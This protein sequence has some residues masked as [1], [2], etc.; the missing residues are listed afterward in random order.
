[1]REPRSLDEL[2]TPCAVVDL[3]R[4]SANLDKMASYT[5]Q[6]RLSL[7]PHTKTHKTPEL[8]HEQ[9]R[10]GASGVTVA[11][12]HEAEVMSSVSEN[13][14]L[15]Y[16]PVSYPKLQRLIPIAEKVN[17]TIA[18]DS[19]EALEGV[20]RTLERTNARVSV[21]VEIDAGMHR[22]G[23][24]TPAD[25]IAVA[26]KLGDSTNTRFA[27]VLFYPGHIRQH[28]EEQKHD[29]ASTRALINEFLSEFVA[30]GLAPARVSGGSTPTAYASHNFDGVTEIRPGTYIFN[31]RTTAAMGACDWSE[32]AYSILAT[33]VSTS[34]A[35]QAVVDAGSKAVFK[36]ELRGVPN[37]EGFGALLDRPDVVVKSMSE[38]HGILDL[39]RSTWRPRVGDRVR[40]V[41]NH[42]CVSVNLHQ[43]LWL[44]RDGELQGNYEIAARGW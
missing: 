16:P 27:G 18:V 6:H 28:V 37:G 41:P 42:V 13:I 29:I 19:L 33:V 39:S 22:V 43:R 34:V 32:C 2:F 10:R 44:E 38:E 23:A 4:M 9:L 36:E 11:T 14:L 12:L 24:V 25:A 1:M 17:L 15:A 31:D 8:A 35:K 40:I 26:R 7:W 30:G 3:D 5:A 20:Q 21:L